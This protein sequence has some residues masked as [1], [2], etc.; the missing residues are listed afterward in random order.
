[1]LNAYELTAKGVGIAIYPASVQSYV[2]KDVVVKKITNPDVTARY[3]LVKSAKGTL[4]LVAQ[5]FWDF[6]TKASENR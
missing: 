6:V 5:T 4:S 1:M 3:I 2:N